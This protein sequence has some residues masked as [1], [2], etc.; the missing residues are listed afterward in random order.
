[1]SQALAGVGSQRQPKGL[2]GYFQR[3]ELPLHS[4]AFLLPAMFL[5]EV[6]TTYHPSDPIAFRMMQ[7]FFRDLGATGR[8][9]PALALAGILLSWHIARRDAWTVKIETLWVM[10]FESIAL[11]LPLLALGAAFARWNIHLPLAA[12]TTGWR[13]E[14]VLSLGAGVYEE[15]VFRLILM[16]AV[17]LLLADVLRAP[18]FVSNLLMV[19]TSAV[20][21]SLYHY[22][23]TESFELR[24]FV[25]RTIAGIYFAVLFL[26]RGFGITAGCH[27]FYDVLI[28]ALQAMAIRPA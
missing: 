14:T 5:F 10:A 26:T 25:F 17:F 11:A 12:Q 24:S 7:T 18:K 16:T 1:M 28:V 15:A 6:G 13:D 19:L 2:D 3:S 8:F 23:G 27:I 21:F 4:L 22:L 20:L 9:L